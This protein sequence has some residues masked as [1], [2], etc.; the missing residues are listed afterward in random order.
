MTK[1]VSI[2]LDSIFTNSNEDECPI[3]LYTFSKMGIITESFKMLVVNNL[4]V[5]VDLDTTDISENSKKYPLWFTMEIMAETKGGVTL[6]KEYL[7]DLG[8]Y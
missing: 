8:F 7:I 4:N 1:T 2:P 6:T 5:T 3:E